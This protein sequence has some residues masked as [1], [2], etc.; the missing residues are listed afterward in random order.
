MAHPGYGIRLRSS[1]HSDRGRVRQNNE[2]SVRLWAEQH[3]VMAIVADG[4]GGAVAGEEASRIAVETIHNAFLNGTHRQ[5]H[6]YA[7]TAANELANQL[8][9][10]IHEANR[11]IIQRVADA[12]QLKGMGTTLTMAFARRSEV[13]LAH[14]G[15]SR[16]Y[17]IDGVDGEIQ[18]LTK[19]HSFVQALVDAGHITADE[20]EHH[21]MKN[22]LYRALG[23]ADELDIDVESGVRLHLGDRLVLCSDGLTLHLSPED[24]AST[25]MASTDPNEIGDR[26]VEIANS[27]GGKDNISVIVIIAEQDESE[28]LDE[29]SAAFDFDDEAPTLPMNPDWSKLTR[30]ASLSEMSDDAPQSA[31]P[32]DPSRNAD[33]SDEPA[34][35]YLSYYGEGTDTLEPIQ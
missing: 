22:V 1:A 30:S 19:D 14:V 17:Y 32:D 16:A 34:D 9:T 7:D 10:A 23:Q 33:N 24:I 5:P 26:L 4:M 18:Q 35:E 15:D 25:A 6:D 31:S 2:D 21:P 12:P 27:R 28:E 3:N 13:I 20:A 11:K 8:A 29:F